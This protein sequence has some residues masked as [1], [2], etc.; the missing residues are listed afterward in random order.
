MFEKLFSSLVDKGNV[1]FISFGLGSSKNGSDLLLLLVFSEFSV[2]VESSP[3]LFSVI[4]YFRS[5]LP[6]LLSLLLNP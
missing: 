5:L 2:S 6:L 1:I 4:L 3:V